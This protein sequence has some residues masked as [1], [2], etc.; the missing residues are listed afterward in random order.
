MVSAIGGGKVVTQYEVLLVESPAPAG[1][2]LDSLPP[3]QYD[4]RIEGDGLVTEVKRGV[5]VFPRRDGSLNAVVRPGQGAHI[6]EYATGG[7]ARE[8]VAA[9]LAKL[10]AALADLQKARQAK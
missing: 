2:T 4:V 3:G 10:E 7:L 9:R 1:T 5:Q 8:E 6:V